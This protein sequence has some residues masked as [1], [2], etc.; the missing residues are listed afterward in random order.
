MPSVCNLGRV[1]TAPGRYFLAFSTDIRPRQGRSFL[2][3]MTLPSGTKMS[4]EK[5][6]ICLLGAVGT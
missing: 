1:P 2:N 6:L 5:I 4:V 3:L